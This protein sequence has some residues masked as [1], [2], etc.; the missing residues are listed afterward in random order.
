[1]VFSRTLDKIL[2]LLHGSHVTTR[3]RSVR[4]KTE[5]L[6]LPTAEEVIINVGREHGNPEVHRKAAE[7]GSIILS[8]FV[9]GVLV[10]P[11]NDP[12]LAF[13][14]AALLGVLSTH[15]VLKALR[16]Y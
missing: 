3:L 15:R 7:A 13:S 14:F 6:P 16:G 12:V 10:H 8:V 5:K 9:S 11:T 2:F 4:K 1:M